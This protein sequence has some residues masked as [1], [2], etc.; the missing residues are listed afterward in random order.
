MV[1]LIIILEKKIFIEICQ[2]RTFVDLLGI[3]KYKYIMM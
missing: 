2:L 3:S 1:Q